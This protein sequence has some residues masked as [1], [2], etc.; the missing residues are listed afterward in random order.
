MSQSLHIL[1]PGSPL[2]DRLS[3]VCTLAWLAR[4]L[5]RRFVLT[6]PSLLLDDVSAVFRVP[7][8]TSRKAICSRSVGPPLTPLSTLPLFAGSV[9]FVCERRASLVIA[10][11]GPSGVFSP[12]PSS[13]G[14]AFSPHKV[15]LV[16]RS[17]RVVSLLRFRGLV[18]TGGD[19]GGDAGSTGSE[20]VWDDEALGPD[21]SGLKN[22][23]IDPRVAGSG[24][25]S[26]GDRG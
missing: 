25:G 2:M 18:R 4:H 12:P 6:E 21:L 5:A 16:S 20:V 23:S 3:V 9:P 22:D 26:S 7:G 8:C 17:G 19:G 10:A 14:V 13:L 15:S 24:L 11:S 1:N